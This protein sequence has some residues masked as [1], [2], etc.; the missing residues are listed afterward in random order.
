M[1]GQVCSPHEEH[2]CRGLHRV[3]SKPCYLGQKFQ[4][5]RA[6]F[7]CCMPDS[8][9]KPVWFQQGRGWQ[10]G[11]GEAKLWERH[12]PSQVGSGSV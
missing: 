1:M 8:A 6:G 5:A 11:R 9:G 4:R 12:M 2:L 10:E 7:T 3:R